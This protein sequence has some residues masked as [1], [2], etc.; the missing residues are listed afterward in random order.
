MNLTKSFLAPVYDFNIGGVY[1][2][3]ETIFKVGRNNTYY[4]LN[5]FRNTITGINN[6][7]QTKM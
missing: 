4:F 2:S 7:Y 3:D 6:L 1:N 5:V